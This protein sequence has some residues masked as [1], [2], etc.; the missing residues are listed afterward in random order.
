MNFKVDTLSLINDGNEM[1]K[2]TDELNRLLDEMFEKI[3][4]MNQ[5]PY[6]TWT[7]TS[8]NEYIARTKIE[9]EEFYLVSDIA[10]SYGATLVDIGNKYE[11]ALRRIGI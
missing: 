9:K 4:K 8:A 5:E 2:Y 3:E 6:P 1:I 11:N 7:G 10:R